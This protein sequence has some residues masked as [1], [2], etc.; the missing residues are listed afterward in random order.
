[1]SV[2]KNEEK[3]YDLRTLD[4]YLSRGLIKQTE[5]EKYLKSLPDDEGNYQLV[6]IDD[7]SESEDQE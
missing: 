3:L 5:V 7:D 1:M 6:Q 4:N 2:K